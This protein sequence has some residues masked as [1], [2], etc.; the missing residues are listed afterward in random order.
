MLRRCLILLI[1]VGLLKPAFACLPPMYEPEPREI[2]IEIAQGLGGDCYYKRVPQPEHTK[3]WTREESWR[4]EFYSSAVSKSPVF[5]KDYYYE[6][7]IVCVESQKGEKHVSQV[8]RNGASSVNDKDWL[9]FLIDDQ[10]VHSYAPIDVIQSEKNTLQAGDTCNPQYTIYENSD[11]NFI[12]DEEINRYV[13][14]VRTLDNHIVRF[15]FLTGAKIPVDQPLDALLTDAISHGDVE[16]VGE[17]LLRG[18]DPN[19][20]NIIDGTPLHLAA[21]LENLEIARI[22]LESG[23]EADV[24]NINH[25]LIDDYDY[26]SVEHQPVHVAAENGD[27]GMIELLWGF[28]ANIS[29]RVT[30]TSDS[31]ISPGEILS[32][33]EVAIKNDHG[34]VVSYLIDKG[35]LLTPI[36]LELAVESRKVELTRFLIEQ[37]VEIT[38]GAIINAIVSLDVGMLELL[39]QAGANM[40]EIC[41]LC[42]LTE[43]SQDN[44]NAI[45]NMA[46]FL[47]NQGAD[48]NGTEDRNPLS[49]TIYPNNLVLARFLLENGV[50]VNKKLSDDSI[51]LRSA[52]FRGQPEMV[53]L[54]LDYGADANYRDD[55]GIPLIYSAI[56]LENQKIV[57]MLLEAGA[58][59]DVTIIFPHDEPPLPVPLLFILLDGSKKREMLPLLI[60]YSV[61]VNAIHPE[62]GDNALQHIVK[63]VAKTVKKGTILIIVNG[64]S[65]EEL[66]AADY[67][68]AQQLLEAG[69]DVNHR[70]TDGKT[71]MDMFT[72]I[73]IG[74]EYQY[75]ADRFMNLVSSH[76]LR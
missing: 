58:N 35:A 67:S 64:A 30:W 37:N 21:Q 5:T 54:L 10:V 8:N 31:F 4:T 23:A 75:L 41:T 55:M 43:S 2:K 38:R 7:P 39:L 57:E 48:I 18:A 45:Q 34:P 71:A 28:G 76:T 9:E 15:D 11:K 17:I 74:E 1:F 49:A 68:V 24:K 33:L 44:E 25:N 50:A 13:Y 62:T 42:T 27:L 22:L 60:Q 66:Y 65:G 72:S 51:V 19:K 6:G 69:I 29:Q 61:D 70:N 73:E 53:Q 47:I 32:P 16:T 52:I 3:E 26:G 40:Q 14:E 20:G 59:P 56:N 36:A 46:N 12:L 63:H